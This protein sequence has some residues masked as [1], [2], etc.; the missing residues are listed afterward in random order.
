MVKPETRSAM[1][2]LDMFISSAL[3]KS[4]LE[5]R[6]PKKAIDIDL[7]YNL[8]GYWDIRVAEEPYIES[9][10]DKKVLESPLEDYPNCPDTILRELRFSYKTDHKI[11]N[12]TFCTRY[13][14]GNY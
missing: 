11:I 7:A 10:I 12:L 1:S 5:L 2:M 14:N 3:K 6:H 9:I 4:N 8:L 13:A